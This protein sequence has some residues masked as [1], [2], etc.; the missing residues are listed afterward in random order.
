MSSSR[1]A[2]E[3]SSAA[4]TEAQA[5]R[6]SGVLSPS[7]GANEAPGTPPKSSV[8][9]GW[10]F[11]LAR[12][13]VVIYASIVALM[14]IFQRSLLYHPH[15][16]ASISEEDAG[17]PQ[18][19][20]AGVTVPGHDGTPLQGW[21]TLDRP[22]SSRD[23]IVPALQASKKPLII[24]FQGNAGNRLRNAGVL[25]PFTQ[26][27]FHVLYVDHRG[28]GVNPGSPTEHDLVKDGRAIWDYAR[29][30][31]GIPADRLVLFGES[32]GG[33]IAVAVAQSTCLDGQPP[34][35]LVVSSTFS[36][37]RRMAQYLYPYVPVR[38][39]L[40]D[41]FLSSERIADVTCPLLQFHGTADTIVPVGIGRELFAAM[42][43]ASASGLA[44]KYV[45]IEG[46]DHYDI[47]SSILSKELPAFARL[48]GCLL[49]DETPR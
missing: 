21:L 46:G 26:L 39:I 5:E 32:L 30:T 11:R 35:G 31:L 44:K 2:D 43:A 42:P 23:D 3:A 18:F 27:G 24:Y 15:R 48:A 13:V 33:G 16:E 22:A 17:F 34:A 8:L 14:A 37:I 40:I 6:P 25:R 4:S 49:T 12:M 28:Y 9:G 29:T 36:S 19:Q 7:T 1:E 41:S 20:V 38:P 45:E 10:A 47:P